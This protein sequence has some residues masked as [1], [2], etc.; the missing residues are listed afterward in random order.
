M[1]NP[2]ANLKRALVIAILATTAIYVIVALAALG[3]Y[4]GANRA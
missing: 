1:D 3:N 2:R 4:A